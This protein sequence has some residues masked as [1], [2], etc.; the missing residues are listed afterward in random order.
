MPWKET[1]KMD[2][3]MEFALKAGDREEVVRGV[4]AKAFRPQTQ[5]APGLVGTR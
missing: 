1:Q 3:R 5:A 4:K 2:Q